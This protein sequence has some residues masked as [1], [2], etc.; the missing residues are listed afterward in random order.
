MHEGHRQRTVAKGLR[1]MATLIGPSPGLGLRD[2]A[3][4][5]LA[6]AAQLE[7]GIM[8]IAVVGG[9]TG[10]KSTLINALLGKEVLPT[11]IDVTTLVTTKVVAGTCLD[12]VTLVHKDGQ[13]EPMTHEEFRETIRLLPE[14]VPP[15]GEDF[16]MPDR[17][18]IY[19]SAVVESDDSFCEAGLHFIDTLGFSG[20]KELDNI[21]MRALT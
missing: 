15:I 2:A 10:G 16:K 14:E 19:D 11:G 12:K 9:F 3:E 1:D 17:L 18:K 4:D 8:R 20:D 21:T 6:R 5:L 13:R 7:E